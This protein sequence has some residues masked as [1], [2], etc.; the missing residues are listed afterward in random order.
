M[1]LNKNGFSFIIKK[2]NL[3]EPIFLFKKRCNFIINLFFIKS[4]EYNKLIQLSYIWS[5]IYF[6][7]VKY[8]NTIMKQIVTKSHN[9]FLIKYEFGTFGTISFR[10]YSK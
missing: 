6:L 10:S 1:E 7:N 9:F 2:E 3:N 8:S 4:I 5:N